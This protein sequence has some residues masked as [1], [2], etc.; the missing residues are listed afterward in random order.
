[1]A[2]LA[3]EENAKLP[4]QFVNFAYYKLDPAYLLLD[5]ETRKAGVA[6]LTEVL[7]SWQSKILLYPY[8]TF[9]VRAET[10]FLLW[11]ISYHLDDF[12]KM[13]TEM[14]RT[15]LGKYLQ[16]PYSFLA[17]TKTSIYVDDH[18]HEG[19][20]S[21]RNQIVIGG[22]KYL[23]VYP[24]VKTRPWYVLDKEER[25]RIMRQHIKFGHEFPSVKLNTTYSFGLDDQD[26]V[27][28]FETDYPADFLDLVQ[29]LRET[30]SSL[31]TQRDTPI[32][33]C[34]Q[35]E[36]GEMLAHISGI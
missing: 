36:I 21:V 16:T 4:R 9:G 23:F 5:D 33:T 13:A 20:E 11:R 24:F 30:E 2:N 3:A 31:F 18:V 1:M 29:G 8:T 10:D 35:Q 12:E 7:K 27:V 34:T 25:Q 32:I 14:R 26:F 19:Q 6:E 17:M 28:A 22:G 15:H